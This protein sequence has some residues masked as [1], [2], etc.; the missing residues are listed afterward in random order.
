MVLHALKWYEKNIC[1]VDGV[2]LLQ[3][4]SPFRNLKIIERGI[5]LFKKNPNAS[6]ISVS[7]AK[8]NPLKCFKIIDNK[9]TNILNLDVN[10]FSDK[11]LDKFYELN[12]SVYITNVKLLKKNKSFYSKEMIPL[13]MFEFNESIDI[14]TE[15]DWKLAEYL[16]YTRLNE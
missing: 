6:V 5:N 3:P 2:L 13:P 12:G 9:M 14:D 15:K 10:D 1:K 4:T 16:C 11:N 8:S 7:P